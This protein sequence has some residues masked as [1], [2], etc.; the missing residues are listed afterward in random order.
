MTEIQTLPA[1]TKP[2][3]DTDHVPQTREPTAAH[4]VKTKPGESAA[5]KVLEA[6]IYGT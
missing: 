3:L 6:R 2:D 5:A 1:P 4:I